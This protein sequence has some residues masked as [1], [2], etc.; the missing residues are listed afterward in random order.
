M[1]GGDGEGGGCAEL[2]YGYGGKGRGL[3]AELGEIPAASAG[4]TELTRAGMTGLLRAGVTELICAG[5]T[6][7]GGCEQAL[8]AGRERFFHA[9]DD[10]GVG[11]QADQEALLGAGDAV[12]E[13]LVESDCALVFAD[14]A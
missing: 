3:G 14:H 13:A 6:E 7:L 5:V 10:F 12:A 11:G 2:G 1:R 4:M 9:V 8:V